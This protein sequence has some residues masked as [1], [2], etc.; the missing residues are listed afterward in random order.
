MQLNV[1]RGGEHLSPQERELWFRM[2]AHRSHALHDPAERCAKARAG[3][4]ARFER[5]ARELHP[6][7]SEATIRRVAEQLRKA[8]YCEFALKGRIA[9][10][11]KAAGRNA[12]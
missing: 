8:Y 10:A 9:K 7:A 2:L 4:E 12:A 3:M 5:Q 1:G 6:Q 11:A